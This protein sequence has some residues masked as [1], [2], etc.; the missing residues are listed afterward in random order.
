MAKKRITK[1][2][3]LSKDELILKLEMI[4]YRFE[5]G[6]EVIRASDVINSVKTI[7]QMKGFNESEK[8]EI[9]YKDF[10]LDI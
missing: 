2:K 10:R 7:A 3:T 5:D 1:P 4:I 6:D 9:T 8:T